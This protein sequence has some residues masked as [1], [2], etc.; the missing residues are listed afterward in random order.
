MKAYISK[1]AARAAERIHEG[2]RQRAD[3][4]N[5][6]S[7]ELLAAIESLETSGGFGTSYPTARHPQ[8]RRVLLPKSRCHVYFEVDEGKQVINILHV[9]DGRRERGPS[10]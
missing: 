4:P 10:L 5:T 1:R 3:H 9:W 7:V 8:L 6:F 2:W